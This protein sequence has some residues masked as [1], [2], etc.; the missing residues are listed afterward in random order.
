[1][2]AD[3]ADINHAVRIVDPHDKTILV[4]RDVEHS[5]TVSQNAGRP[6]IPLD[7]GRARP[8]ASNRSGK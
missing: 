7:V 8:E 4:P 2:G 5:A 6:D 1:M 3:E